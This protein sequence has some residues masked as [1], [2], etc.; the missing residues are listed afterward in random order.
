[1]IGAAQ[2]EEGDALPTSYCGQ[3]AAASKLMIDCAGSVG[4]IGRR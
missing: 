2:H 3:V 4:T 1:M